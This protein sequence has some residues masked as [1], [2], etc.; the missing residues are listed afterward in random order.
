MDLESFRQYCLSK[1]GVEETF[2]FDEVTLVFKVMGKMFALTGLDN[3]GFSLTLKCDPE[4]AVELREEWEEIQPAWH[5]SKSH[6]NM[7]DCEGNLDDAFL[8]HLVDH[9]YDLVVAG[10]PKK[11]RNELQQ[12]E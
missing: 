6:W 8:Y 11:L 10:L 3:P 9:S 5:M 7:I 4:K 2:P 1:K 12:L